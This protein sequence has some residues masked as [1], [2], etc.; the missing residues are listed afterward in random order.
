MSNALRAL[1]ISLTA[2]VVFTGVLIVMTG[3]GDMDAFALGLLGAAF[4]WLAFAALAP[5]E[6]RP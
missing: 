2:F 4:T 5:W 3:L 6:R 1:L